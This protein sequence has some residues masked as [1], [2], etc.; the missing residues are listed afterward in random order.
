VEPIG[1]RSDY[2][3]EPVR[4]GRAAVQEAERR[5]LG[6]TGLQKVQIEAIYADFSSLRALT[7]ESLTC[8]VP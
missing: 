1:E 2:S 6:R 8:H 3:I 5:R 4:V 7:S